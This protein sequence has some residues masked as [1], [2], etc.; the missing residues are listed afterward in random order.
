MN[1]QFGSTTS[2]QADYFP[3][4]KGGLGDTVRM[5]VSVAPRDSEGKDAMKKASALMIVLL[6]GLA[7]ISPAGAITYGEPD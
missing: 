7:W 3:T 1:D 6:L 2:P 4:L 5:L